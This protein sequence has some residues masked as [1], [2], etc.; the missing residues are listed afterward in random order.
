MSHDELLA[1]KETGRMAHFKA[2]CGGV[3]DP[4]DA[5]DTPVDSFHL[6]HTPGLSGKPKRIELVTVLNID[7]PPAVYPSLERWS[8]L[9]ITGSLAAK[10]TDDV[11]DIM[12]QIMG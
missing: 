7:A 3:L 8:V 10:G 9:P 6:L 4:N 12:R 11:L 5:L 1:D 2:D